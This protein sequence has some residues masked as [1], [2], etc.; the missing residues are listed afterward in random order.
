MMALKEERWGKYIAWCYHIKY[1]HEDNIIYLESTLYFFVYLNLLCKTLAPRWSR[2]FYMFLHSCCYLRWF[3]S[4]SV[5]FLVKCLPEYLTLSFSLSLS[6]LF[7][8]HILTSISCWLSELLGS[9]DNS[10]GQ[11]E[12]ECASWRWAEPI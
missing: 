9:E 2:F 5:L 8:F 6:S 7:L 1:H 10:K 11:M 12:K 4:F 3:S